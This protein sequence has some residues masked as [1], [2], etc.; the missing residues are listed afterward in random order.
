MPNA[1]QTTPTPFLAFS[2]VGSYESNGTPLIFTGIN[3]LSPQF[4][5]DVNGIIKTSSAFI[6]NSSTYTDVSLNAT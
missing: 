3:T 6:I 1:P 2:N 5:L 4:P